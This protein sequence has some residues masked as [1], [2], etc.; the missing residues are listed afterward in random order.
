MN[1]LPNP[2]V[3]GALPA[4]AIV[5]ALAGAVGSVE[6]AIVRLR[7]DDAEPD[8]VEKIL[9]AAG[10]PDLGDVVAHHNT[11]TRAVAI[12]DHR[13]ILPEQEWTPIAE[14]GPLLA[15]VVERLRAY[16][17]ELLIQAEPEITVSTH[18]ALLLAMADEG[19]VGETLQ[20][21]VLVEDAA[22]MWQRLRIERARIA[23]PDELSEVLSASR[24]LLVEHFEQDGE[25]LRRGRRA[26]ARLAEGTP[27]EVVKRLSSPRTMRTLAR[28]RQDLEDFCSA[29]RADAAGWLVDED[30]EIADALDSIDSPLK[31]VSGVLGRSLAKVSE[32]RHRGGESDD[33]AGAEDSVPEQD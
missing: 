30:P 8:T 21:L 7:G 5:R 1:D 28:L 23:E 2:D 19:R 9:A 33:E 6:A 16:A 27:L 3:S 4:D 22:T 11:L 17:F 25:L 20:L 24:T 29:C 18:V 26:L 14:L 31:S 13:G 32:A 12:A 10:A 15:V